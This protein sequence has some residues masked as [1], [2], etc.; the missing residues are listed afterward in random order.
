MPNEIYLPIPHS[1]R[2]GSNNVST[3]Y[4]IF[5]ITGN[6]GLVDYYSTFLTALYDKA[7]NTSSGKGARFEVYSKSLA[8]FEVPADKY[9]VDDRSRGKGPFG[10]EKQIDFCMENLRRITAVG[11]NDVVADSANGM[12]RVK[13]KQVILMGHSV[14]TYIIL[15]MLRKHNEARRKRAKAASTDETAYSSQDEEAYRIVGCIFLFP[16]VMRLLESPRGESIGVSE[17]ML[18]P[19]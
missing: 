7:N 15:E 16:T 1:S 9:A 2:N 13:R 8:G 11:A 14:G 4:L 6:P 17:S 5:Y 18:F 12:K 3:D 19:R 10:L